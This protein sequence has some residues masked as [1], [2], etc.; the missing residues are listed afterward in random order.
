MYVS[1][2]AICKKNREKTQPFLFYSKKVFLLLHKQ[3]INIITPKKLES[4]CDF[5]A[6]PV[7]TIHGRGNGLS[8]DG[9]IELIESASFFCSV[10]SLR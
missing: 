6:A 3:K 4:L 8:Y 5:K 7:N 2:T 1:G 9:M 10:P